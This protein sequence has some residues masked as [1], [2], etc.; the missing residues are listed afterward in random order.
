MTVP[1][2]A[3]TSLDD[4]RDALNTAIKDQCDDS[5]MYAAIYSLSSCLLHLLF[6]AKIPKSK[7]DTDS[8]ALYCNSKCWVSKYTSLITNTNDLLYPQPD[9]SSTFTPNCPTTISHPRNET[10]SGTMASI[11]HQEDTTSWENTSLRDWCKWYHL[12]DSNNRN[13][14]KRVVTLRRKTRA[15][16]IVSS[17]LLSTIFPFI[18]FHMSWVLGFENIYLS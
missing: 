9:S 11:S 1:E 18:S 10:R 3:S 17:T 15:Q 14:R 2:V 16:K 8:I 4:R 13:D 6:K 12:L 5:R 7:F